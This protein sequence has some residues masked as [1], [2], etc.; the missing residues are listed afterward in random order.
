MK[1]AIYIACFC[2]ILSGC[3]DKTEWT[4]FFYPDAN[5]LTN[6]RVEHGFSSIDECRNWVESQVSYDLNYD[7]EC[8]KGCEYRADW[9]LYVCEITEQ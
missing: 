1:K 4:G 6:Y 8:G 7:Y 5:D 3:F 2:L 9:D